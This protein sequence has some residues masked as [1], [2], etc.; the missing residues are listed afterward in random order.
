VQEQLLQSRGGDVLLSVAKTLKAGQQS[1]GSTD[2]DE[3]TNDINT[4]VPGAQGS[5]DESGETGDDESKRLVSNPVRLA[6]NG[7]ANNPMHLSK[8]KLAFDLL[9]VTITRMFSQPGL[10]SLNSSRQKAMFSLVSLSTSA[11]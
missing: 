6:A 9:S 5:G 10:D 11:C 4:K 2:H 1:S 7:L 8:T 3:G